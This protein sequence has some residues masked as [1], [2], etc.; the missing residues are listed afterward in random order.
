MPER[1][2]PVDLEGGAHF[3]LVFCTVGD[4]P[5][6]ARQAEVF[7][8]DRRTG[9]QMIAV[10]KNCRRRLLAS[11]N[12]INYSKRIEYVAGNNFP[13]IGRETWLTEIVSMRLSVV[14]QEHHR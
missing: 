5:V 7:G 8:G 4:V 3:R 6:L 9:L 12:G 13:R 1:V 14:G 10:G 2:E 11:A